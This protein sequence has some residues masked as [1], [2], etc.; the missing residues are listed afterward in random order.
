MTNEFAANLI[1]LRGEKDLTQ[2]ELGDA[3]GVSPSQISRYEAGVAFPRKTVLRK[4]A[5]A[6]GVSADELQG[7]EPSP[8]QDFRIYEGFSS[9]LVAARSA[10]IIS[11]RKL[12]SM[13]GIEPSILLQFELG[14]LYPTQEDVVKLSEALEV[15]RSVLAGTQGEEEAVRIKL[16]SD[17]PEGDDEMM[18]LSPAVYQSFLRAAERLG[19]SPEGYLNLILESAAAAAADTSGKPNPMKDFLEAFKKGSE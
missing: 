16:V 7:A 1:Y 8:G 3:A 9:R 11:R 10:K 5:D 6:L 18:S 13:T 17:G 12:S 19:L 2:Q 4:I 15:D 14:D